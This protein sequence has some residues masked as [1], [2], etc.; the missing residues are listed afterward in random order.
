MNRLLI[1]LPFAALFGGCGTPPATVAPGH[2]IQAASAAHKYK[3]CPVLDME[4]ERE[5]YGYIGPL[6]FGGNLTKEAQQARAA[7]EAA[8]RDVSSPCPVRQGPWPRQASRSSQPAS[9]EETPPLGDRM[10]V[11]NFGGGQTV[12]S[13]R[14]CIGAVV[15]GQCYG[16]ILP[17]YSRSHQTCYG[18]M[19]NGTCTG[20]MF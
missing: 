3:A 4:L 1:V 13:Q 9:V 5:P 17:D 18:Q 8:E 11:P 7:R 12:Y 2:D 19:L 15:N 16:S 20:P 10:S 14:E 6:L